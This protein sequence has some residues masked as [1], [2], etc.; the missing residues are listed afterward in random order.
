MAKTVEKYQLAWQHSGKKGSI[1]LLFE[2]GGGKQIN[3][4]DADDF[5]VMSELLRNEKPMWYDENQ[6]LL[7]TTHEPIGEAE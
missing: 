3:G 5:L 4:L 7:A 6:S 1:V 2:G